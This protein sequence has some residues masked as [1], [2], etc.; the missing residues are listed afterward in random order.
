MKASKWM[1]NVMFALAA[2]LFLPLGLMANNIRIIGTPTVAKNA[3]QKTAKINFTLAWDNSWKTSKPANWDAAW[4]FVKCWDGDQWSHAYLEKSGHTA[5]NTGATGYRV[6]NLAK[7]ASNLQ[8]EI[9]LGLSKVY[10]Q[11]Y[12]NPN[13]LPDTSVVGVFLRRKDLGSGN[14]VVPGISLLW[15]YNKQGFAYDDDLVVKVFAIEMVY[16]PEGEFWLGGL[17]DHGKNYWSFTAYN[18]TFGNPF[19]V[20]SEAEI[21]T[22]ADTDP[23]H[24]TC[25]SNSSFETSGSLP[26]R[27]PKGYAAFYIMKYELTQEAYCDFLNTLDMGQQNGRIQGNIESIGVGTSFWDGTANSLANRRIFIEVAARTPLV[28]FG[29]DANNNG[30]VNETTPITI[31]RDG[32]TDNIDMSIDGQDLAMDG[33]SF[34]D[35]AA[36]ADFA[37]LRPMTELEYEKACRGDQAVRDDEYAWA[38]PARLWFDPVYHWA[39]MNW[40]DASSNLHSRGFLYPMQGQERAPG[41]NMGI[42]HSYQYRDWWNWWYYHGPLRVGLF[43]DTTTTRLASGASYWGVMNMSDNVQELCIHAGYNSTGRKFQGVHGDGQLTANGDANTPEWNLSETWHYFIPRG[44]RAW[45]GTV[46]GSS[47]GNGY[48]NFPA[49]WGTETWHGTVS[50]RWYSGHGN[51]GKARPITTYQFG[52]RCVRTANATE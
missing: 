41:Y 2:V 46:W 49:D 34:F 16:V 10:R 14:V 13:A 5:G 20:R 47:C 4:I 25:V 51:G 22:R 52:I 43:A 21:I 3:D 17:G 33:V 40:H 35:L 32:T 37:G 27:F 28:S 30:K 48:N 31:S 8:M 44:F 19:R 45:D 6:Q 11:W 29:V 42:T 9:E 39:A 50:S 7:N 38:S 18:S 26:A 36:Y 23:T 24:L 1:Y 12:A 15:N